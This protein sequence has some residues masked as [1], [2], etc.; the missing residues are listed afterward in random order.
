MWLFVLPY[1]KVNLHVEEI[2]YCL[3]K[4]T[5]P[6]PPHLHVL[7]S[8]QEYSKTPEPA[9][10]G[11]GGGR[12]GRRGTG[13]PPHITGCTSSA[14]GVKLHRDPEMPQ[15]YLIILEHIPGHGRILREPLIE[16]ARVGGNGIYHLGHLSS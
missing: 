8:R 5:L 15:T 11:A 2:K 3:L 16:P 9:S 13:C 1:T 10:L 7:E 12:E 14:T 4:G 6:F